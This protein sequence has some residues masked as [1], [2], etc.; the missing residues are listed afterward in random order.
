MKG[1]VFFCQLPQSNHGN[2]KDLIQLAASLLQFKS[3][4]KNVLHCLWEDRAADQPVKAEMRGDL[5]LS[6][7]RDV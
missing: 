4:N 3:S 1:S 5:W 7:S 2:Q 6:P